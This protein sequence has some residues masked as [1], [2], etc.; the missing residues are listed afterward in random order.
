M[1]GLMANLRGLAARLLWMAT[2]TA[3]L[4]GSSGAD[5]AKPKGRAAKVEKLPEVIRSQESDDVDGK[6][7]A[8]PA[9]AVPK[10][11]ASL[12]PSDLDALIEKGLAAGKTP[13]AEPTSDDEFIRRAYLDLHGKLPAP[14]SIRQ[15]AQSRGRDKRARLVD[16]LLEHPD[17]AEN[18]ARYWRDVIE[19]RSPVEN[20][21]NLDYALFTKW[22]AAQ[23][24]ANKRWDKVATEIITASGRNDE[25]GATVFPQ[26]EEFHAVE[27]AGEVSRIFLG[28]QIQ[29]AQCHDHPSD[30]W[31]RQQFHEFAAFFSGIK[32]EVVQKQEK[33][34]R[35]IFKVVATGAT[36][37]AMPDLKDPSRK[38]PVSPRFFLGDPPRIGE[39]VGAEA[40]LALAAKYVTSTENPWFARAFINR[41]WSATMGEGFYNPVDDLGPTRTPHS[42]EILDLLADHWQ[43]SGYDIRWLFRTILNT[44]AYQRQSRSSNTAAGRTP[45]ASNVPS[46]LRADQIFDALVQALN[47]DQVPAA[48][49]KA[50]VAKGAQ[51][52]KA[53]RKP[54]D[55]SE[56]PGR[57]EVN[58]TFGVD[59][60]TPNDDVV[61]TI[62]Q[63]LYL[64]NGPII[65]RQVQARPGTMLGELV[66]IAPNERAAVDALYLK[67]LARHP[68]AK[69][70]S[71]CL[72][73][74]SSVGDHREGFEDI[75]WALINSTE[76]VSRR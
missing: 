59:P 41:I 24:A 66:G 52:K 42:P 38:V 47:L 73:H 16:S 10:G 23:F 67:V 64:M 53:A 31:K 33:G 2:A 1:V 18:W 76:F 14:G 22:L 39:Q 34:Q 62:P 11:A 28:V 69:E 13:L 32:R 57:R 25:N 21:R 26:A 35:A 30:P 55:P 71:A 29:C 60:S 9:S 75:L 61:G 27:I 72:H 50:A 6:P 8:G 36:H 45:F 3:A 37:Y 70:M 43:R 49:L 48:Q 56:P 40:R 63:A 20:D 74:V 65:A 4:V 15:F 54:D 17:Y 12:Q 58:H 7:Q 19:Y 46:R 5:G 68:N 44:Q 51:A